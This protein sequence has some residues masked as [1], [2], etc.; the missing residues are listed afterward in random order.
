MDVPPCHAAYNSQ[1]VNCASTCIAGGGRSPLL[2]VFCSSPPPHN[3]VLLQ[4]LNSQ[5]YEASGSESGFFN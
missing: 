3:I 4:T 1:I 5:N 2:S